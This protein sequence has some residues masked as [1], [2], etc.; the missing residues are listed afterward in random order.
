VSSLS[1]DHWQEISPYLDEVL[2]LPEQERAK[3]L[4]SFRRKRP[5]LAELVQELLNEQSILAKE[6]FLE[7]SPIT[8]A[9]EASLAGRIVGA[10]KLLSPIGQGGMGSVWLA[11]R[12]DGRFE[13]QVAVKFLNFAVA[14]QG[15]E[16]FKR[17]GSILGRLADP[18]IAE[19]MD[20]GVTENGEPYL[21][22]EYVEGEPIDEYCDRRSLDVNAR[23]RLFLDVLS[24]VAQAHANLVVH[25]DIKPSNVLVRNDGCVKLLD[26][27]IA[28]L[29][30]DDAK[31]AAATMLT[32][33]GGGALTPQFAA[34]EQ[35]TG[36][37]IT[38]A[39]DVYALGVLFYL[40]LTGR[41]PAGPPTQSTAALVKAIVD[42]ET[43]RASDV[44]G[45]DDAIAAATKR[46]TT[47]DKLRRQ[48][49]GDLDT[50]VAKAL[51]KNPAERYSSVTAL[52]DDLQRYLNHEPIKARPDTILY[53]GSKFLRRYWLPVSAAG[54][55]IASLGA[56]LYVANRERLIAEDRF[57]DL[58]QLSSRMFDL[59]DTIRN[60][61]GSTVARQALVSAAQQYLDGLAV[62]APRDVDLAEEV[63]EGYWRVARIQGIPTD[64][65]LGE[66]A[67]AEVSLK[68]ANELM[69]KVIAA[70]PHDRSALFFSA[71]ITGGRMILAQ[72]E[73]RDADAA[74]CG[75]KAAE[76]IEAFLR[77][78][79]A[80]PQEQNQVAA[81]Y[82]NI[83]LVFL[84]MRLNAEAVR[85]AQ[86]S[87]ELAR[88]IP[89]GEYMV[90]LGLSLLGSA[91][92]YAGD[93]DGALGA[94]QEARS[95]ADHATYPSEVT[96][97]LN[98]YGILLREGLLFD[99]DDGVS[100]GRPVDAVE[101]LR[102][103]FNMME[104][105]AERD[106]HDV[107]SRL[108][109]ASAGNALGN[110]LRRGNPREA[111][112]TYDLSLNR[113][114]EAQN[115]LS[116]IRRQALL[117]ANSSYAL[118]SLHRPAE[119]DHRIVMA[120]S[121]LKQTHDYPATEIKLDSEA[122]VVLCAQGDYEAENGDPRRGV[123]VY[124][125]LLKEVMAANP[126]VLTDL[127]DVPRLS[128][129]YENLGQLYER[130]GNPAQA[131]AMRTRR[132]D[133]WNQ[134]DRKLPGN[135]FVLRQVAAATVPSRLL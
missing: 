10:Y 111:L 20:A 45:S 1:P 51:K 134:W 123:D 110:A 75:R 35:I 73:N 113:I 37:T 121:L 70:R 102:K 80:S 114:R 86:R 126:D 30:S 76:R 108:R 90:P 89:S 42:T 56:G 3:W 71:N 49:R 68:R 117:L 26:F 18:H 2:S 50:I 22:L 125:Q 95:I 6:R 17:E 33:E 98:E 7:R 32:I 81:M 119:A 19:L 91:L 58:K 122:Y 43:R 104:N 16:R 54:L 79:D 124:E 66:P 9:S 21:V 60:L 87:V 106:P 12:T 13:R 29:L 107:V 67:K 101:P 131:E 82:A 15:A 41:H 27:G 31:S 72:E 105:V 25:R 94:L 112:A 38:T 127:R 47:P 132:L 88:R 100:L 135:A 96:R 93:L 8:P 52:A 130:T 59:D 77:L 48:L 63:G 14:A 120:L 78:G 44:I 62:N 84:N 53:V 74:A 55:V 103:T 64:L 85:Y 65:N 61:P 109:L 116:A 83:A 118:R 128:R 46:A 11:E 69:E 24:A 34:P 133:L 28:K 5:D 129:V 36:G 39:T 4:D 97:T 92:R 99:E 40:L 115:N 57:N 23:V